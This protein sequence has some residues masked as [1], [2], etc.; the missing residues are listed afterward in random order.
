MSKVASERVERE[1]VLNEFG[2]L[3]SGSL[4]LLHISHI[5]MNRMIFFSDG[6]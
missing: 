3:V 4:S 6:H 2:T 1:G 5:K